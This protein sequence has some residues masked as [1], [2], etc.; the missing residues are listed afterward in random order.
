MEGWKKILTSV[1]PALLGIAN[2]AIFTTVM[3]AMFNHAI[4]E[5]NKTAFDILLGMLGGNLT[6]VMSYYFGSSSGSSRKDETIQ[7]MTLKGEPKG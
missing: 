7:Q 3:I 5:A 2:I 1:T 4:P 6:T